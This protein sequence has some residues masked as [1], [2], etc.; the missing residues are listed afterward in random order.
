MTP[1]AKE[2]GGRTIQEAVADVFD[3]KLTRDI[4]RRDRGVQSERAQW[5]GGRRVQRL[6]HQRTPLS[7][8][9]GRQ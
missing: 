8:V 9:G 2:N 5:I 7:G 1:Y 3:Q 4:H 6:M